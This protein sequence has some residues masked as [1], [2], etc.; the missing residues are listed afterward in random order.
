[1]HR[2]VDAEFIPAN[3]HVE[4]EDCP[5][6]ENDREQPQHHAYQVLLGY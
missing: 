6:D 3:L 2:I 4:V 5:S 1:M